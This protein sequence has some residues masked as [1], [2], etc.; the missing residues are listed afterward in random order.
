MNMVKT[1]KNNYLIPQDFINKEQVIKYKSDILL[2]S[3]EIYQISLFD[4]DQKI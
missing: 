3:L 4:E 2:D 1:E